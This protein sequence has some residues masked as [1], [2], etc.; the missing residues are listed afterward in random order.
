MKKIEKENIPNQ[1]ENIDDDGKNS[2][3]QLTADTVEK[4]GLDKLT[5]EAGDY[6]LVFNEIHEKVEVYYKEGYD[7]RHS[8]TNIEKIDQQIPEQ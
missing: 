2:C 8:L 1:F 7:D 3:Y 6:F 4:W 5:D